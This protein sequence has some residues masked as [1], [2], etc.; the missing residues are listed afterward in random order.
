MT[1]TCSG[2]EGQIIVPPKG[3]FRMNRSGASI[4]ITLVVR[5]ISDQT[6]RDVIVVSQ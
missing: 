2:L 6:R 3:C 5:R 4:L 1:A